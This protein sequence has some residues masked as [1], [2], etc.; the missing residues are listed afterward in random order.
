MPWLV[1]TVLCHFLPALMPFHALT[2]ILRQAGLDFKPRRAN[3]KQR[4][5]LF[6]NVYGDRHGRRVLRVLLF[7][8]MALATRMKAMLHL[9]TCARNCKGAM[10]TPQACSTREK[11]EGGLGKKN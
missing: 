1:H 7:S 4:Q 9:S 2:A 10:L 8:S 11:K 3:D 6:C 5:Q